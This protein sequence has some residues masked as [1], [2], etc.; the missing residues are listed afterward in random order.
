[1]TLHKLTAFVVM[2]IILIV[3]ATLD[4]LHKLPHGFEICGGL[5]LLNSALLISLP[6]EKNPTG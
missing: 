2:P 4:V 1:M 5:V 3:T 6:S